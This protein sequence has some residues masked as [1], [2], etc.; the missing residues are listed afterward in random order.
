MRYSIID[1]S[2]LTAVQRL[3][4]EISV[5][6][7]VCI[8]GDI[9]AFENLVQAILFYDGLFFIDDYKQDFREQRRH[10]FSFL[11]PISAESFPYREFLHA[12][13]ERVKDIILDV[14]GGKVAK[15]D[16][17]DFLERLK[18][19]TTFTWDM[20]SSNWFLTMK[21]L[22]GADTI[23]IDK[24]STLKDMIFLERE[25]GKGTSF[26]DA[27]GRKC[28]L[29]DS[30]GRVIREI[31]EGKR[32]KHEITPEIF[33]F[34]SSLNW[35]SLRTAFYSMVSSKYAADAILHPIRSAFQLSFA[36][37]LGVPEAVFKPIIDKLNDKAVAAIT[38][39]RA[40]TEPVIV[41]MSLPIF[42]AWL[43]KK[44]RDPKK[45]IEAAFELKAKP[46]FVEARRL[47]SELEDHCQDNSRGDFVKLANRLVREIAELSD[48]L[49]Q[50][51]G[52]DTRNGVSVAPLITLMNVVCKLKGLPAIPNLPI[53]V[54]LPD[55]LLEIGTKTGFKGVYRSVVQD[56]VAVERLGDIHDVLSSRINLAPEAGEWRAKTEDVK[57][58]GKA[59]HWKKPM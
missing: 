26:R 19:H 51:Y 2:T 23:D 8:D 22:Q 39:I 52:V 32:N 49:K 55:R 29:L 20:R 58:F 15:N 16:I 43:A 40:N 28:Q 53:K 27:N 50:V 46:E 33:A 34:S 18:M 59:S 13:S 3:L 17:G 35:L 1:N 11:V 6:N 12:S 10:Y 54:P 9:A 24:Y 36:S 38:E 45:I 41:D 42:S 14:Q 4:G 21:M 47:L 5:V 57:F 7:K 31:K 30:Q 56:L 44:T 25:A 37:R 48:K